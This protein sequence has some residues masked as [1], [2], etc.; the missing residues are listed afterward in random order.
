MAGYHLDNIS[1]G[2]L[3]C[4]S[5]ILE[6]AAEFQDAVAQGCVIMAIHE[7]S[8]LYGA[9]E[10][11]LAQYHITMEDLRVMNVVTARAFQSGERQ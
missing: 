1:K 11:Y 6:E 3:G 9:M 7:L 8:D 4:P 5:K 10:A 2:V